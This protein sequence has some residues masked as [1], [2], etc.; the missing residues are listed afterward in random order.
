MNN[1][2]KKARILEIATELRQCLGCAYGCCD[3]A[4]VLLAAMLRKAG[5][6]PRLV[7]GMF[8]TD[9]RKL[10]RGLSVDDEHWWIECSGYLIDI[11]A[12][13]FNEEL[14]EGQMPEVVCTPRKDAS[15]RYVGGRLANPRTSPLKALERIRGDWKPS[16]IRKEL[17]SLGLGAGPRHAG[18]NG[19]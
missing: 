1:T 4:S 14:P 10:L 2:A 17:A 18:R 12:D 11:T 3:D 15:W 5:L 16:A 19:E 6:K 9:L 8:Y 13:Q 7:K